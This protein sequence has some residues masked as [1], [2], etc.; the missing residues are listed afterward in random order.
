MNKKIEEEKE[1][2]LDEDAL[3]STGCE[4]HWSLY[5]YDLMHQWIPLLLGRRMAAEWRRKRERRRR[6]KEKMSLEEAHH[7]RKSWIRA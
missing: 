3:V 4:L 1:H 6:F 7:H 2:H 5:A